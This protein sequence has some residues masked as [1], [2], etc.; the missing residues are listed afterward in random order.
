MSSPSTFDIVEMSAPVSL[1]IA[2]H[3]PEK[4]SGALSCIP[5]EL[6]Q[7]IFGHVAEWPTTPWTER[8]PEPPDTNLRCVP[9]FLASVCTQWRI[10]ALQTPELWS[11]ISLMNGALR[12]PVAYADACLDRS[13]QWPLDIVADF[14]HIGAMSGAEAM[15]IWGRIISQNF[16]WK[17]C[18]FTFTSTPEITWD[19]WP[20]STPNLKELV[21]VV[22][23]SE[24]YNDPFASAEDHPNRPLPIAAHLRRLSFNSLHLPYIDFRD[25][26]YLSVHLHERDCSILWDVLSQA[27]LLCEARIFWPHSL[28][29][30]EGPPRQTISL[31][32]LQRLEIYGRTAADFDL[33]VE[34]FD[35]P[36]LQTVV[37]SAYTCNKLATLFERVAPQVNKLIVRYE[38]GSLLAE[39]DAR[40]ICHLRF[41]KEIVICGIEMD[42]VTGEDMTADASSLGFSDFFEIL[43][44]S[45]E[46]KRLNTLKMVDCKQHWS[47]SSSEL[48]NHSFEVSFL[49]EGKGWADPRIGVF[50]VIPEAGYWGS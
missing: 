47:S 6:L 11:T 44:D 16:Y 21:V 28:E 15:A 2:P 19:K 41:L 10:T 24:H 8:R 38:W 39:E 5:I 32:N 3:A 31:P 45:P 23:E 36:A 18:H 46:M 13:A 1:K 22:Q 30:L 7:T 48:A 27:P 29:R 37:V 25:L 12:D 40:A 14:S 34:T 17:R 20:E 9:F 49:G 4:V 33:Y 42:Y 35:L 43:R 50:M 26:E